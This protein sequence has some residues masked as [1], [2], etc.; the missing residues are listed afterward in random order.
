[1]LIDMW[2]IACTSALPD[3]QPE[4]HILS[5]PLVLWSS[6]VQ[7]FCDPEILAEIIVTNGLPEA[8]QGG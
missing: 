6:H 2:K 4:G 3:E 1:M 8:I 5:P 7:G